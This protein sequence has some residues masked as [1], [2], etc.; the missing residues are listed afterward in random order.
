MNELEQL[1]T[2]FAEKSILIDELQQYHHLQNDL[3]FS[4]ALLKLDFRLGDSS[5]IEFLIFE[6]ELNELYTNLKRCDER[7]I[8]LSNRMESISFQMM[9][10]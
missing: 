2:F 6:N 4:I 1:K 10:L 9:N 3:E 7:I 5:E 8:R